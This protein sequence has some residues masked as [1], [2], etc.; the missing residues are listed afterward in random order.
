MPGEK[1]NGPTEN[2]VVSDLG[3]DVSGTVAE[4]VVDVVDVVDDVVDVVDDVVDVVVDVVD[5]FVDVVDVVVDLDGDDMS[6]T[7]DVQ[8]DLS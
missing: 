5:V 6:G 4:Q 2:V 7:V 8:V 3:G 1:Y